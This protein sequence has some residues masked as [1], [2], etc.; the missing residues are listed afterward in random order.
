MYEPTDEE[1]VSVLSSHDE[2]SVSTGRKSRIVAHR[3]L[4]RALYHVL[5]N[6]SEVPSDVVEQN[7]KDL[8]TIADMYECRSVVDL[9]LQKH[10]LHFKASN[11]FLARCVNDPA[12]TLDLAMLTRCDWMF[13]EVF[14]HLLSDVDNWDYNQPLIQ[15]HHLELLFERKTTAYQLLLKEVFLRIMTTVGVC[16]EN[17]SDAV[18]IGRLFFQQQL[19]AL[20]QNWL[21]SEPVLA[22]RNL[23]N[24]TLPLCCLG[25]LESLETFT[26]GFGK[27]RFA[28][29]KKGYEHCLTEAS[30][31]ASE[32]LANPCN[33]STKFQKGARRS[34]P[35]LLCFTIIEDELPWKQK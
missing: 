28:Q 8:L 7:L 33:V 14:V 3:Q 17:E 29:A 30:E 5:F 12:G 18:N 19:A 31:I 4:L 26:K 2:T 22:I 27:G 34:V 21:S 15:K 1:G 24:K 11:E 9:P 23:I 10:L 25:W 35:A 13:M 20:L 16:D 32:L 6:L